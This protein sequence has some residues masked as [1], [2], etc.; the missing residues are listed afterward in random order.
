[1]MMRREIKNGHLHRD[2]GEETRMLAHFR[3]ISTRTEDFLRVSEPPEFSCAQATAEITCTVKSFI[4]VLLVI[5]TATITSARAEDTVIPAMFPDREQFVA[6]LEKEQAVPN[7]AIE[8]T[9]ISVPH[10]LLAA[11]LIARG[12]LLA[13]SGHYDRV[14]IVSP[15]HF[16]KSRR[17]LA[18]TRK[19]IDTAFGMLL[20]DCEVTG[21]LIANPE[22]FDE[23]D[24]FAHE[25]GVAALLPFVKRFFPDARIVPIVVSRD[26]S[27]A[28]WDDAVATLEK[29]SGPGT[30]I[31]QSTDYSH[32]LPHRIAQQRDQE[33]LNVIAAE[34]L[35]QLSHLV[36]PDHMDSKG[37]QY[38]QMRLQAGMK[39][40]HGIVIANRSSSEYSAMG[41]RTTSYLVTA[42]A[43][44]TAAGS[45]L[46]YPDHDVFYFSGDVF[47]GR[48][49]TQPMSDPA[50]AQAVIDEILKVTRGAP[51][52]VNLEGVLLDDPP[53]GVDPDL[54]VMHAGLAV[55]I[56][57]ALNVKAAGLANNHS[58]DL[59]DG[60]VRESSAVLRRAGI[61]PLQHMKVTELGPL[62][63]VAINF[64]G[65]RDYK[66]YPVIKRVEDLA[67]LCKAKVRSPLVALVHWGE[68]YTTSPRPEDLAAGQKMR[69][70]GVNI[71]VGAHSHQA[72][73]AIASM[74][75]GGYQ[76]T[77]SL[78]NLLFD[79][80]SERASS[81]MLE[82][83]LFNQGTVATR[84]VPLGN[85]F[86]LAQ[87]RLA[88]KASEAPPARPAAASPPDDA[89]ELRPPARRPCIS[90]GR[91]C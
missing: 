72:V 21:A 48:W 42:Y 74:Q 40:A 7:P 16:S 69:T 47:I 28:H 2:Q 80:K 8:V 76:M 78:G 54:H 57:K 17:P 70:C 56:L 46:R 26:S 24:L 11:D 41:A 10:H 5:V 91:S 34:D 86:E 45:Q 4:L 38:I 30:L 62:G 33:T 58:T 55:P 61:L 85:M 83:R 13:A 36:Q 89:P 82:L 19:D 65:V 23:S 79:Q 18:T 50:A 60:S 35:D 39:G 68:E 27:R 77:F 14:I 90:P 49:L 53:P 29:F 15:D 64:I 20:N 84:L 81:A 67:S 31:V 75:G 59:G 37:S 63:I 6:A 71:I 3:G 43:T 44:D 9:G 88:T 25:H 87:A 32:Y 52:I 22:L 66:G 12:F 1:M 51:L 73:K